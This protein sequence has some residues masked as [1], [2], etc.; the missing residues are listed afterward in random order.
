MLDELF[1]VLD[2][3]FAVLDELFAVF[4]ELFAVLDELFAVFDELFAV[5]DEL[6]AVLDELF[7]VLDDFFAVLDEL[8]AVP[9]DFKELDV[10][11]LLELSFAVL[12]GSFSAQPVSDRI[13]AA[14]TK[15]AVIVF[16]IFCPLQNI[17]FAFR[18]TWLL[19]QCLWLIFFDDLG[20]GFYPIDSR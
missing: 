16:F 19:F 14:K 15:I 12:S 4:D 9:D 6:F 18:T 13:I 3:L 5:L 10:L 1:A 20:G 8:F 7:V 11:V 2:E 17:T